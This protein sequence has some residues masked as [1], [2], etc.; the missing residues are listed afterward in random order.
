MPDYLNMDIGDLVRMLRRKGPAPPPAGRTET[1]SSEARLRVVP[2]GQRLEFWSL[3]FDQPLLS[4][5]AQLAGSP[6]KFSESADRG[7]VQVVVSIPVQAEGVEEQTVR[8]TYQSPPGVEP[9]ELL[10]KTRAS[11]A[12]VPPDSTMVEFLFTHG[13]LEFR[14]IFE[15]SNR[16]SVDHFEPV[17]D[18][19]PIFR[20]IPPVAQMA[21]FLRAMTQQRRSTATTLEDVVRTAGSGRTRERSTLL[22]SQFPRNHDFQSPRVQAL[23]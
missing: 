10:E 9:G 7:R 6:S 3:L 21:A 5:R 11:S 18:R 4:I 15:F 12:R 8:L 22:L 1:V 13:E 17:I 2:N 14:Y 23:V 19:R 16:I 20:A